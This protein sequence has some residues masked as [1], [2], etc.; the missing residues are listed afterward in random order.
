[1]PGYSLIIGCRLASMATG[2][3]ISN[4]T[5]MSQE[6]GIRSMRTTYH[7]GNL[8]SVCIELGTDLI[9]RQG[10]DSFSMRALARSA[11]VSPTAIYCH[12]K[13]RAALFKAVAVQ[14]AEHLHQRL[15]KNA[16]DSGYALAALEQLLCEYA[17]QSPHLFNLVFCHRH[18]DPAELVL[19]ITKMQTL[20]STAS[21]TGEPAKLQ[22]MGEAAVVPGWSVMLGMATSYAAGHRAFASGHHA[23]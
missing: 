19:Q 7:H 18:D 15:R 23:S 17:C 21:V 8:R 9:R 13:S 2:A 14:E 20:V 5:R 6:A 1:L 16:E 12:F 22:K 11:G 3:R 10:L 4:C